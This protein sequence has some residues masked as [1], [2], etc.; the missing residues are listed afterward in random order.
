METQRLIL[1]VSGP[2]GVGK[3]T[4]ARGLKKRSKGM[5]FS[6]SATTREPRGNEEHGRDY[7]F[8]TEQEFL[9]M[10][11]R[12]EFLEHARVH[13]HLYGTPRK[14]V[15]Q[16]LARG[17]DALCDIDVQG[18]AQMKES[19]PDAVLVFVL[20]PSREELERRLRGRKTESEEA[21][22]R[23][24]DAAMDELRAAEKC[25]F[26][27]LVVNDRV[28]EAVGELEGILLAE[29]CRFFRRTRE[30][31]WTSWTLTS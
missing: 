2:S 8:L 20:P 27:Y 29:K 1:V 16:E 19:R 14:P 6:V 9:D 23:R 11:E 26:A 22:R 13:G 5:F 28:D 3:S 17:Q 24:L 31:T 4:L 18:A 21:L 25:G 7:L 15:E 30:P 12:E 10:I